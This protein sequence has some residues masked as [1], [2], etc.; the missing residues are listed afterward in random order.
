MEKVTPSPR[1]GRRGDPNLL[2]GRR[3]GKPLSGYQRELMD[4]LLPRVAVDP[5]QPIDPAALFARPIAGL[6]LEIGFG[7]GEHLLGAA[8]RTRDVGFIGCEPF[9]NGTARALADLATAD[10]DNVRLHCGDAGEVIDALPDGALDRVYLFYPDPWPK[11]RQQKRRFVSDA[12]LA[13]LARA[14]RSGAELRF[15]TDIDDYC[16]WTLSRVLRSPDFLWL[17]ATAADWQRPWADWVQTRYE[18]KA[19]AEGRR[20]CYITALRR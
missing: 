13:R 6:H 17:A 18:T 19:F 8:T 11:R 16:G 7:A 5:S 4:V 12:L 10:L 9:V 3:V 15:A 2:R 1:D 20:G 14:M